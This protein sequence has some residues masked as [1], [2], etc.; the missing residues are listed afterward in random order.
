MMS[1]SET[2]S[3]IAE[4][5][6]ENELRVSVHRLG[7]VHHQTFR[8]QVQHMIKFFNPIISKVL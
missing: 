7:E 2:S 5:L 6:E 1:L 3:Y 4:K 8:K